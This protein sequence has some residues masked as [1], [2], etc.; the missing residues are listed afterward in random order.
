[1]RLTTK[2]LNKEII[3]QPSVLIDED[4]SND[5]PHLGKPLH[6]SKMQNNDFITVPEVLL[7]K[8]ESKL[9]SA[10]KALE[11]LEE[12]T[13]SKTGSILRSQPLEN[14]LELYTDN[15]P[16]KLKNI[17]NQKNL[18]SGDVNVGDSHKPPQSEE[19]GSN[20]QLIIK[21][22][23]KDTVSLSNR[24]KS[25]EETNGWSESLGSLMPGDDITV[26]GPKDIFFVGNGIKLPLNMVKKNDGALHLSVDVD[27]LCGCKNETCPHNKTAIEETVGSILEKEAELKDQLEHASDV[28]ER[29]DPNSKASI[30]SILP[31]TKKVKDPSLEETKNERTNNFSSEELQHENPGILKRSAEDPN[32]DVEIINIKPE[33]LLQ[34]SKIIKLDAVDFK[35]Q[36]EEK[37]NVV[38][39]TTSPISSTWKSIFPQTQTKTASEFLKDYW[40]KGVEDLSSRFSTL[41]ALTPLTIPINIFTHPFKAQIKTDSTTETAKI[42]QVISTNGVHNSFGLFSMPQQIFQTLLPTKVKIGN[43]ISTPNSI[44]DGVF[45]TIGPQIQSFSTESV[46]IFSEKYDRISKV[47]GPHEFEGLHDHLKG[48]D[49]TLEKHKKENEK[50]LQEGSKIL[51]KANDEAAKQQ[52]GIVDNFMNWLKGVGLRNENN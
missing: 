1:M 13:N 6:A 29:G 42:P 36:K 19:T 31:D 9:T 25:S 51:S 33:T 8:A 34:Q 26:N 44:I 37:N 28:L 27:K 40:S 18:I 52:I 39:S 11:N 24:M 30:Q 43:F 14:S 7:E 48:L 49:D 20:S 12:D 16:N 2:N 32:E 46:R 38:H 17:N 47:R 35:K 23:G 21:D 45:T 10:E 22:L 41:D 5:I 3:T 4:D 15:S 50:L